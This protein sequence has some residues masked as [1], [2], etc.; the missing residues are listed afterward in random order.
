[1]MELSTQE[2]VAQAE[3][4]PGTEAAAHQSRVNRSARSATSCGIPT[5]AATARW[6]VA[7]GAW[8][9]ARDQ[10][11]L[12]HRVECLGVGARRGEQ[13]GDDLGEGDADP[14]GGIDELGPRPV[15]HGEEPVLG[16]RLLGVHQRQGGVLVLELES[17]HGLHERTQRGRR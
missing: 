12:R 13:L 4:G 2:A 9:S 16:E 6:R 1:M 5:A 8:T 3:Y 14:L 7:S 11:E 17:G 15:P 10:V